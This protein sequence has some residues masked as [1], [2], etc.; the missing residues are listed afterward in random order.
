MESAERPRATRQ[1][2]RAVLDHVVD[3]LH[4]HDVGDLMG[5]C[6]YGSGTMWHHELAECGGWHHGALDMDMGINE[7]GQKIVRVLLLVGADLVDQAV[8]Y[9]DLCRVNLLCQ[10]VDEVAF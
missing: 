7:P 1:G 9:M 3:A 2:R 10:Y 4:S 5:V 6:N 8:L